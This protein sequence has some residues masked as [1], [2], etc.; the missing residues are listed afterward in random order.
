MIHAKHRAACIEAQ[1]DAFIQQWF[2]CKI[3]G[4]LRAE[5]KQAMTAAFDSLHGIARVLP[6][7]PT[8]EILMD[9]WAIP[10]ERCREAYRRATAAA[11]L[12]R[13]QPD[14]D[15]EDEMA[16]KYKL[17]NPLEKKP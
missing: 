1:T 4:R 11:D 12:T 15:A 2:G 7:E 3:G 10:T 9:L 14:P 17:T 16:E 6:L 5:V 13:P 8:G